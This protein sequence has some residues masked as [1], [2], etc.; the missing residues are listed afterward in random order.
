MR[1][2]LKI[3]LDTCFAVLG[4]ITA[5]GLA[6]YSALLLQRPVYV[7]FSLAIIPVCASW[8]YLKKRNNTESS[9]R[10]STRVTLVSSILFFLAF[11]ASLVIFHSR[12]DLY[13]RP[14]SY[15]VLTSIMA[16][17]VAVGVL[18]LPLKRGLISLMF[19]QILLTGAS[20]LLTQQFLFPSVVGVDPWF[21]RFVVDTVLETGYTPI[22]DYSYLPSFHTITSAGSLIS[23]LDYQMSSALTVG[24]FSMI[25]VSI[26]TFLIGRAMFDERV[27]LLAALMVTIAP[28]HVL[29]GVWVIPNTLACMVIPLIVLMLLKMEER[30][31]VH[32][33]L[34]AVFLMLAVL[35]TH[36][37]IS[38]SL[39]ILLFGAWLSYSLYK[40]LSDRE[41]LTPFSFGFVLVFS[42]SMVGWWTFVD[43]KMAYLISLAFDGFRMGVAGTVP[44]TV[45][46]YVFTVSL[47][48]Q[49]I[50][51]VGMFIFFAI[52]LLGCF[53]L[54]SKKGRSPHRFTYMAIGLAFLILGSTALAFGITDL[55]SR[56]FHIAEIMLAVP[57]ALS[58]L[59]I[60]SGKV[61]KRLSAIATFILV[62]SL[63]FLSIISPCTQVDN[64]YLSPNTGIRFAYTESE[65]YGV[66][67]MVDNHEGLIF[68]DFDFGN[69]AVSY[70]IGFDRDRLSP[71]D[72]SLLEN[73]FNKGALMAIRTE[74]ADQPIRLGGLPYKLGYDPS[75]TL[76]IA[77]PAFNKI[78]DSRDL[79]MFQ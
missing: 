59:I 68:T 76:S 22:S 8:L 69:N 40:M 41:V 30:K 15:F 52:S 4:M 57:V 34:L 53:Y 38:M 48:E 19:V 78:Y 31:N 32:I 51:Y 49:A 16:G 61:R 72:Q 77:D 66:H 50:R 46:N 21:H 20:V 36:A 64:N 75:Y 2:I 58:I 60:G 6:A 65:L 13:S 67:F 42:T 3:E 11:T 55:E 25:V 73:S 44:G 39:A 7:L 54:M 70:Y 62:A 23:N 47:T 74:I 37:L 18:H 10:T 71:S 28:Y 24:L 1:T 79:S 17:L 12:A 5:I 63:A 27:G 45:A 43:N 9:I 56:W 26:T 14:L 33:I 29:F 35:M